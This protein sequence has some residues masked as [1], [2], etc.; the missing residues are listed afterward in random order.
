VSFEDGV[1]NIG[2]PNAYGREWLA[3][4]LTSTL[5]RLM[6]GIFNQQLVVEFIVT[7]EILENEEDGFLDKEIP[8]PDKH[9]YEAGAAR[10]PGKKFGAPSKKVAYFSGM[11]IRTLWR[12]AAKPEP[13]KRLS[14]LVQS[15]PG[16]VYP[17]TRTRV[18]SDERSCWD[19]R[20]WVSC[21]DSS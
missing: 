11:S 8:V 14:W 7:E 4:R 9:P 1:T 6:T 10:Q 16:S 17:N 2:T 19:I 20:F 18:G 15:P 21:M 3:S 13:W 5:T 12:W